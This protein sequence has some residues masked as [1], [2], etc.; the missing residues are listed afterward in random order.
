M[1]TRNIY[2]MLLCYENQAKRREIT[3]TQTAISLWFRVLLA[4]SYWPV[5]NPAFLKI[6]RCPLFSEFD[7]NNFQLFTRWRTCNFCFDTG[8]FVPTF[9]SMVRFCMYLLA[10][11]WG[12]AFA[13][14]ELKND[15][16]LWRGVGMFRIDWAIKKLI[17]CNP[18]T[19]TALFVLRS[20]I[21]IY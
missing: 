9:I 5:H 19:C 16:C 13:A 3:Y 14:F 15:K 18:F 21:M 12:R 20:Y 11:Q 7:S 17:F 10:P 2:G 6:F 8:A 4:Y 1:N